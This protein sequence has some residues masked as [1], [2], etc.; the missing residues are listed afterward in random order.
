MENRKERVE[1]DVLKS[2]LYV[3]LGS[4]WALACFLF[5]SYFT[6]LKLQMHQRSFNAVARRIS[7]EG[8]W[9]LS[10][11]PGRLD[12]CRHGVGACEGRQKPQE[13]GLDSGG[14]RHPRPCGSRSPGTLS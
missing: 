1:A 7:C 13:V 2:E 3:Q 4:D 5:L 10:S 6:G 14:E 9:E 11:D 12:V 8:P